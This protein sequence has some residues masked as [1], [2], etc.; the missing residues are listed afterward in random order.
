MRHR[1]TF[2]EQCLKS[3][4]RGEASANRRERASPLLLES[5]LLRN[6]VPS[7]PQPKQ[8][9]RAQDLCAQAARRSRQPSPAPHKPRQAPTQ[10]RSSETADRGQASLERLWPRYR[11]SSARTSSSSVRATASDTRRDSSSAR[12]SCDAHALRQTTASDGPEGPH[13][14]AREPARELGQSSQRLRTTPPRQSPSTREAS[15]HPKSEDT[16]S[17]HPQ[18][19][20]SN[21]DRA[22]LAPP[23]EDTPASERDGTRATP[24]SSTGGVAAG[25]A[26]A[27]REPSSSASGGGRSGQGVEGR[28]PVRGGGGSTSEGRDIA[29]GGSGESASEARSVES[30]GEGSTG[31]DGGAGSRR[32]S[33]CGCRAYQP[34]MSVASVDSEPASDSGAARAGSRTAN[35]ARWSSSDRCCARDQ[36]E[37]PHRVSRPFAF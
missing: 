37:D 20:Q 6:I 2:L 1:C 24:R 32:S 25:S 11:S 31:T 15:P 21:P 3:V 30:G 19:P 13:T 14:L 16:S 17:K 26:T 23:R 36:A 10:A 34:V 29:G 9:P 28:V 27:A 8:C 5:K 18:R 4:C 7:R 35:S 33:S 22:A 12:A